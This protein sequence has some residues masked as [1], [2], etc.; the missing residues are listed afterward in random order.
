[1]TIAAAKWL[2]VG[3]VDAASWHSWIYY[4]VFV[5]GVIWSLARGAGRAGVELLWVTAVTTALI[6]LSSLMTV[7]GIGWSH[8][9][10]DR[11][12]DGV[13]IVGAIG[14]ALTARAA[15]RRAVDG[16]RDS[17]WSR[18]AKGVLVNA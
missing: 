5:L 15:A 11:L 17:V 7:A 9:G 14:F 4:S 10:T 1:M 8:G 2:P 3:V 6:P 13:A 18:G 12:I 16:P